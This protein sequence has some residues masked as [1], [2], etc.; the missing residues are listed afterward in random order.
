MSNQVESVERS[1]WEKTEILYH[2]KK[3]NT[4]REKRSEFMVFIEA[5]M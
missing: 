2:K 5:F 3:Y 1:V 4:N